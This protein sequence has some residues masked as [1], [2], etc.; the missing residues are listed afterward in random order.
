[1]CWA[2]DVGNTHYKVGII[3]NNK[4]VKV[5]RFRTIRDQSIDEYYFQLRNICRE[6]SIANIPKLWIASVVPSVTIAFEMLSKTKNIDAAFIDTQSSFSFSL[7][8]RIG[9]KIGADILI[10]AEAAVD[11]VGENVIIVCAGTA[12][13][14]F[15]V[16]E[17]VLIGGAI[18]PGIKGSVESLIDSAAL[19]STTYLEL[20]EKA[21]GQT[22][23]GAMSSGILYGFAGLVDGLITRMKK[24][25]GK[26]DIPVVASGGMISKIE[27]ASCEIDSVYPD[28]GMRGILSLAKKN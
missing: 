28:L 13:T 24:E 21:I 2:I 19:L 6:H 8:E 15:A 22:T 23:E 11:I 5:Y 26:N 25:I 27:R 10:L 16:V 14:I 1:M 9:K 7:D 3:K 12:T 18:A 20:P 4:V 17:G